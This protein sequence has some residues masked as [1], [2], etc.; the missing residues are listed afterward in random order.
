MFFPFFMK[1]NS[2]T[3]LIKL[4]SESANAIPAPFIGITRMKAKTI[5]KANPIIPAMVGDFASD[6]A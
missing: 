6:W 4:A 1:K 3:V 5:L 2:A